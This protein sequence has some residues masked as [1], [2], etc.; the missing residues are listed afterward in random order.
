MKILSSLVFFY[1]LPPPHPQFINTFTLLLWWQQF[2]R[3]WTLP[4]RLRDFYYPRTV[5]H[6]VL[7]EWTLSVCFSWRL[8][9]SSAHESF[10]INYNQYINVPNAVLYLSF[11]SK[12]LKPRSTTQNCTLLDFSRCGRY[13]RA[14]QRPAR[15]TGISCVIACDG[16]GRRCCVSM[17]TTTI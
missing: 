3:K 1:N 9:A 5:C 16:S 12:T 17:P 8:F 6:I 15:M 4:V 7:S 13:I 14:Q 10:R 11:I 2:R